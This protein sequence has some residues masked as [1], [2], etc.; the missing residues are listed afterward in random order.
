[1]QV[2]QQAL[3]VAL[4]EAVN[5]LRLLDLLG[6]CLAPASWLLDLPEAAQGGTRLTPVM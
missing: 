5:A 2:S 6:P 4:A 1:V 3:K